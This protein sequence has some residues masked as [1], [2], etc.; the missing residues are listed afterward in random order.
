[1]NQ[2]DNIDRWE[3]LI[4]ALQ[5]TCTSLDTF[6]RSQNAEDLIDYEPFLEY[7]D[8]QIFQCEECHWWY[9]VDAMEED[10]ICEDCA[11]Y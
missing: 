1:M 9:S 4:Y 10:M 7:L 3:S 11:S 2:I 8:D 5:E 6:L